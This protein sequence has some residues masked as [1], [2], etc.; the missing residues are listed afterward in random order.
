MQAPEMYGHHNSI[1]VPD[2][3]GNDEMQD[4]H[5]PNQ[6]GN[7]IRQLHRNLT[8]GGFP[9]MMQ[10]VAFE[11]QQSMMQS[12]AMGSQMMPQP[13]AMMKKNSQPIIYNHHIQ[14]AKPMHSKNK[15]GQGLT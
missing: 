13:W 1:Q 11:Q 7:N 14:Q 10:S 5:Q 9:Q 12:N 3:L 6:K 4:M 8:Q 15:S 2:G